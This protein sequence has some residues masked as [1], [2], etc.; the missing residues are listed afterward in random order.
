MRIKRRHAERV[1][2][3]NVLNIVQ[4]THAIDIASTVIKRAVALSHALFK[5]VA[6]TSKHSVAH[7]SYRAVGT[8]NRGRGITKRNCLDVTNPNYSSTLT[9]NRQLA[10]CPRGCGLSINDAKNSHNNFY[11]NKNEES[12]HEYIQ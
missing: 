12:I 4:T 10:V 1:H 2:V 9:M 8:L 6:I 7:T 3:A 11:H 5:G